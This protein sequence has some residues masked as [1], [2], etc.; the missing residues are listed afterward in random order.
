MMNEGKR[1][2]E[3]KDI[4]I[5]RLSGVLERWESAFEREE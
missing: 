4:E 1:K 2:S 5:E 3:E